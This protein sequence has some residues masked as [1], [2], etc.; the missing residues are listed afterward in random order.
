MDRVELRQGRSELVSRVS[1][2]RVAQVFKNADVTT[3]HRCPVSPLRPGK[4]QSFGQKILLLFRPVF[5]NSR[6][7]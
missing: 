4:L 7:Y 6:K 3:K 5:R 1:L 2:W